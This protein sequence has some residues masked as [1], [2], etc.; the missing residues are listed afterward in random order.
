MISLVLSGLAS[1]L[2]SGATL[3]LN[4]AQGGAG[5]ANALGNG[6]ANIV[7]T[8]AI[9]VYDVEQLGILLFPSGSTGPISVSVVARLQWSADGVNFVEEKLEQP[10]AV[11]GGVQQ[12]PAVIKEWGPNTLSWPI[13]RPATAVYFKLGLYA[14]SAPAAGDLVT[15][16]VMLQRPDQIEASGS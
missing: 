16:F 4:W 12:F 8:A 11:S 6:V 9:P 13:W 3:K 1:T 14:T 7:Y 10:N 15:T 2:P 5:G